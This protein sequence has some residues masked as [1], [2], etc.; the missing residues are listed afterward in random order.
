MNSK[1]EVLSNLRESRQ[2]KY[3]FLSIQK[4]ISEE[5][6]PKLRSV[7]NEKEVSATV[8][9]ET[10][11][12]PTEER[13]KLIEQAVKED[14]GIKVI[15]DEHSLSASPCNLGTESNGKKLYE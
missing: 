10:A 1:P 12:L 7:L 11:G 2:L 3:V 5:I 14:F 4:L 13:V 6:R 8:I 15:Y 9:Q